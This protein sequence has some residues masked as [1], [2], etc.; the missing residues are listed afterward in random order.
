LLLA[1]QIGGQRRICVCINLTKEDER[2][3]TTQ[4]NDMIEWTNSSGFEE[5]KL[6]DSKIT[7]V[8]EGVIYE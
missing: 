6:R 4:I 7:L 5:I 2:V 3:I 8:V 1:K